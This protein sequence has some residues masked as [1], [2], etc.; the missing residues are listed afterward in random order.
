LSTITNITEKILAE[1]NE[2]A[3]AVLKEA[4]EKTEELLL[5]RRK[6]LETEGERELEKAER[7]AAAMS[8]R[9]VNGA[10]LESRDVLLKARQ[11]LLDRAFDAAAQSLK[12]ISDEEYGLFLKKMLERLDYDSEAVLLVPPSRLSLVQ[13]LAAGIAVKAE[14]TLESGFLV[15]T[16]PSRYNFDFSQLLDFRRNEL[17]RDVLSVLLEGKE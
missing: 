2:Q 10:V 7:T 13:G 12:N 3:E 8:E 4:Q 6:D 9:L 1:A 11:D 16:G 14:E 15:D 17:E 5:K